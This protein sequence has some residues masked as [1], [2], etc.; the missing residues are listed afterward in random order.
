MMASGQSLRLAL[1]GVVVSLLAACSSLPSAGPTSNQIE[2]WEP[3]VGS[4]GERRSERDYVVIDLN[5][6]VVRTLAA[7]YPYGLRSFSTKRVSLPKSKIGVGDVLAVTIWEAG[8]GGLF[9]NSSA[10]SVNMPAMVVDGTGVI[11][12]PYT[13]ALKVSG[14]TPMEIEKLIVERLS[15]RAI[16]PQAVVNIVKNETNTVVLSGDVVKPGRY[17][18]SLQGTRLLDLVADAGGAKFPAQ[19]T[20]ITFIRGDQRGSQSLKAVIDSEAENVYIRAGD[21]V[22]LSHEPKKYTVLGAVPKPGVYPFGAPKVNLL[23][24][25][26]GA[27]GLIDEKA[28]GTGLFVFRHENRKVIEALGARA[29][30]S[31]HYVQVVYRVNMRDPSAYFY[32]KSFMLSDKD[33]LY[34]ANARAVEINKLLVFLRSGTSVVGSLKSATIP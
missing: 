9:S 25:V 22:Y 26:A 10:K 29:M 32:A 18:L 4:E 20:Y 17:P 15:T 1:A 8:E 6:D 14:K 30:Q 7:Q 5:S 31:G 27:G 12:L 3:V 13:G 19:E 11:S 2:G 34:V 33:V 23:E 28:D 16:H 24:A 21:Q